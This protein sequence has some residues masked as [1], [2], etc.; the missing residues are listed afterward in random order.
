MGKRAIE[1]LFATGFKKRIL[2]VYSKAQ[3]FELYDSKGD[4]VRKTLIK[5]SGAQEQAGVLVPRV[6]LEPLRKPIPDIFPQ[7]GCKSYNSC[8]QENQNGNPG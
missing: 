8:V 7:T 3:E 6:S 1:G 4:Y 5:T 2:P